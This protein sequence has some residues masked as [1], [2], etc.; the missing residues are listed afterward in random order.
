MSISTSEPKAVTHLC[1]HA[2]LNSSCPTVIISE[3]DLTAHEL[4]TRHQTLSHMRSKLM[5]PMIPSIGS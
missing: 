5:R 1:V 2:R 3:S 4:R